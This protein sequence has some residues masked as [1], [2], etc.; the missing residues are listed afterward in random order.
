MRSP[1]QIIKGLTSRRKPVDAGAS[2]DEPVAIPDPRANEFA[3]RIAPHPDLDVNL[4]TSD[5]ST[6]HGNEAEHHPDTIGPRAQ[7]PVPTIQSDLSPPQAAK[8]NSPEALNQTAPVEPAVQ[9]SE[10]AA[11]V[12]AVAATT[13]ERYTKPAPAR[14]A[15]GKAI[16]VKAVAERPVAANRTAFG[17]ATE[18]DRE[19][20]ELRS[21]LSEKLRKQNQQ[22]RKLLDRYGE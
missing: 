22:L 17:E 20:R 12:G 21:Q 15:R 18:L 11:G 9:A 1:W 4:G 10:G 7:Q 3:Q 13:P 19:I 8:N 2:A 6:A 14:E 5:Q 16:D